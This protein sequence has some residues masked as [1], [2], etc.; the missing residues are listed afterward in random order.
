MSGFEINWE[1]QWRIHACNYHNGYAHIHFPQ[2]TLKLLPG[3]GF[4]DFSHPTTKLVMRLMEGRVNNKTVIDMGCGSGILSLASLFLGANGA[5]G[6]D[7]DPLAVSHSRQNASLN[8]LDSKT[9]FYLPEQFV[10]PFNTSTLVVMNMISSEQE[11]VLQQH[12][13]L[14]NSIPELII[15]GILVEEQEEYLMRL[16]TKG[17]KK[18]AMLQE[19]GWCAFYLI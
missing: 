1:E 5:I 13:E 9:E 15:S 16:M 19:D 18:Q 17:W 6:V 3:P 12:S 14:W 2:G 8:G 4:G 7:I 10:L 11:I